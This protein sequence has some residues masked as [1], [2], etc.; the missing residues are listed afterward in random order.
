M[1]SQQRG[2]QSVE[3][4]C[5]LLLALA[6]SRV[7]M[8]LRDL[9][10]AADMTPSKAHPYLVSF[11]KLKLIAQDPATGQYDLGEAALQI[12]LAAFQRLSPLRAAQEELK[13]IEV[14]AHYST[15]VSVWGS[16]GPTIVQF[17]EADYPLQVYIR[18]GTVLSLANTAAGQAFAAF[19]P[20]NVIAS[21]LK[22]ERHRF[23]GRTEAISMAALDEITAEVRKLG[24]ARSIGT[25]VPGVNSISAPVFNDRGEMV[26]AI[27]LMRPG[28]PADAD[29]QGATARAAKQC[30][31]RISRRL[32][33]TPPE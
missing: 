23:A 17:T 27:S 25:V 10:K 20:R 4:G 24:I 28:L 1:K 15:A 31:L 9:A 3:I 8:P 33:F 12:G 18:C 16:Q 29:P 30:A 6:R 32:G 21:A 11:A 5:A 13:T 26:L 19:M 22:Q 7:A 14:G 2:I